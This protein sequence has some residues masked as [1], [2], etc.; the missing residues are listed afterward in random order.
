MATN[1]SKRYFHIDK[2]A[3]SEQ[4]CALLDDV[5]S[6]DE[7][8][9]DNLVND[10]ETE[11][12]TEQEISQ[13]AISP[14]TKWQSVKEE[15]KEQTRRIMKVD[16]KSRSYYARRV[17]PRAR[18][19]TQS[20]WNSFPNRNIFFG[21]RPRRAARIDSWTILHAYQNG[22]NFTVT[23]EEMEAFLGINFVMA[24]N[25]L[26]TIAEYWKEGNLICSDGI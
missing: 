23:K 8:E 6:G 14:R 2:N 5:E 16:K 21:D 11:F 7:D 15:T 25:K 24:T 9:I 18:N 26:P 19:I 10:S 4:I 3:S 12:I 13:A 1:S 22:S 20:K 17:S